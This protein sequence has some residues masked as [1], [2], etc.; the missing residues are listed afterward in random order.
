MKRILAVL[1][2]SSLPLLFFPQKKSGKNLQLEKANKE[3]QK[4]NYLIALPLYASEYQKEP[5]NLNTKY[6]LGICYL[7][8]RINHLE[9][10][11]ILRECS[12]NPK[13]DPE[14]HK[15]LGRAYMLNNRLDEA[16][17]CFNRYSTLL[18]KQYIDA[19]Y[20]L[21]QC[22]NAQALLS[23]P[24]SAT[25][26]NM[27][28]SI[29]SPFPDYNPLVNKDESILVFTSRRKENIGGKVVEMDGYRNSDIYYSE[30]INN[31]WN[32]ARNAGRL[33]NTSLD[34]E[35]VSISADGKEIIVY[36]D[37]IDKY[38]DLYFSRRNTGTIE[39]TKMTAFDKLINKNIETSGCQ[40]EE[41]DVLFFARRL[42]V[43]STSD[44]YMC[45]KLPTGNWSQA[46]KLPEP[47]NSSHNE[48][49]PFLSFDGETL[50]FSSD[51]LN[52]MGGYDLFK[53]KWNKEANTFSSPENLGC[54]I[55]STDDERSI[56]VTLNNDLAYISAFRPNG[57][58]D[59]DIYRV[60]F[61]DDDPVSRVYSGRVIL[62]DSLSANQ[63]L[64][65]V[66]N[67]L[68]SNVLSGKEYNF[69]PSSNTGKY[70]MTLPDGLYKIETTAEG[71]ETLEEEMQVSDSG[72]LQ[73]EYN[74]TIFLKK[75]E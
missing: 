27:G 62:G 13:I 54:P 52:S 39:F 61:N 50:Y 3:F 55:N 47:I 66:V 12:L 20:Y 6:K 21:Q 57:F 32:T 73:I 4:G 40:N 31:K 26:Q 72:K 30:M 24:A 28:K 67:I 69:V 11:D 33:I 19:N 48:D 43:N 9:A 71:Y 16:I 7:H 65:V 60:K 5:E 25:F 1:F 51:G 46:L 23:L 74:K 18:P 2:I 34:E 59:L 56:S 15:F 37:H 49:S 44:L 22:K 64:N 70:V 58:G 75:K 45:R 29:N 10:L 8:T 63:E 36:I 41:G 68:A 53:C 17:V 14:V 42:T 35:A 38:G